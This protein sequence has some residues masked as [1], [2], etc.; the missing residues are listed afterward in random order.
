MGFETLNYHKVS[1]LWY[2]VSRLEVG[3]S[4]TSHRVSRPKPC[5]FMVLGRMRRLRRD[6]SLLLAGEPKCHGLVERVLVLNVE[7]RI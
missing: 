4:Q 1:F 7:E 5:K 3:A 2:N 6:L